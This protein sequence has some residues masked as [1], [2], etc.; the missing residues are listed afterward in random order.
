MKEFV[1]EKNRI[2]SDPEMKT[3]KTILRVVN[4]FKEA[5]LPTKC[6]ACGSFFHPRKDQRDNPLEKNRP[7][8][9]YY[10]DGDFATLMRG[11]LC[12]DCSPHFSPV[13][14]PIC[15]RCGIMFKTREGEDHVCG[16]C[17]ES[18]GRFGMARAS[19]VYDQSLVDV[20]HCLKY[21]N[22]IRLARPLGILLFHAFIRYWGE[23]NMD[24]VI[25]V[26][27]HAKKLKKRGF[28]QAFL[29]V[30]EWMEFAEA[31]NMELSGP[32]IEA[33]ALTRSRWTE[34][35]TGLSREKRLRNI[36]NA[37]RVTDFG[38][39]KGKKILLVDDVYTTGATVEECAKV[40]FKAG[41]EQVDVLTLARAMGSGAENRLY[42]PSG[43][44][45]GDGLP[46]ERIRSIG[47]REHEIRISMLQ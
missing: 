47:S 29:L 44:H 4:A 28:N 22:K 14:S 38:K 15:S 25:P 17:I 7:Q 40:L 16:S 37:F 1:P 33:D 27:L 3:R 24:L 19:G 6:L 42:G 35:Q 13:H 23:K 31:L 20:I 18:S 12:P 36:K 32:R 46:D 30:R 43:I 8:R 26:P 9:L 45:P 5:L 21:K 41:A 39:V 11:F 10:P 2:D 34:P